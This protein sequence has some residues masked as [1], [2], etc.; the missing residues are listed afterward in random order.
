MHSTHIHGQWANTKSKVKRQRQ[1]HTRTKPKAETKLYCRFCHSEAKQTEGEK[2]GAESMEL[3]MPDRTEPKL[4]SKLRGSKP[5]VAP[6]ARCLAGGV[7]RSPSPNNLRAIVFM[8]MGLI[9]L[10]GVRGSR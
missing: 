6:F 1:Q 3:V 2:W 8:P 10:D 5:C 7:N 9:Q 4:W